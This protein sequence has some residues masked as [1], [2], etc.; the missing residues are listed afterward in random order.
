MD[1]ITVKVSDLLEQLQLMKED[2][3]DNVVISLLEAEIEEDTKEEIPAS[4]F[5]SA[6]QINGDVEVDYDVVY[7]VE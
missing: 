7:S 2:N 3:M 6:Y 1:K 5:L 4:I